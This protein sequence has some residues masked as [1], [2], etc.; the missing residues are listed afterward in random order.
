MRREAGDQRGRLA[1][2]LLARSHEVFQP[3][4][5]YL[6]KSGAP[7]RSPAARRGARPR[8]RGWRRDR[9]PC[10]SRRGRPVRGG[11]GGA[12]ARRRGAAPARRR[13]RRR[14]GTSRAARRPP[15]AAVTSSET[16]DGA[17][18]PTRRQRH[19]HLRGS[20]RRRQAER[21][22]VK[23]VKQCD[24]RVAG[25]DSALGSVV[26]PVRRVVAATVARAAARP[27]RAP[28]PPRRSPGLLGAGL[29]DAAGDAGARRRP[30]RRLGAAAAAGARALRRGRRWSPASRWACSSARRSS[31]LPGGLGGAARRPRARPRP[32]PPGILARAGRRA[33]GRGRR[34][35]RPAA[36]RRQDAEPEA[37]DDRR[38]G[39]G[40]A[41]RRRSPARGRARGAARRCA[42]DRRAPAPPARAGRDR[43]PAAGAAAAAACWR[44][45]FALSRADWR[46]LDLGPL[47]R[48]RRSRS[49]SASAHGLFWY[50]SPPGAALARALPARRRS[51]SLAVA[52]PRSSALA[53]GRAPARGVAASA[54]RSPTARWGCASA[55]GAGAPR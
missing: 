7:R 34:R 47:V 26:S 40:A 36:A 17:T 31:A 5:T 27:P 16:R 42:R 18:E 21:S 1:L 29:V 19:T 13:G 52:W 44:S 49:C 53:V 10:G 35:R 46:V 32:S 3:P 55:L 12:A 11:G 38:G 30:R 43:P 33:G 50:R 2:V 15:Q 45:S 28:S 14:V 8:A 9:S 39:H 48:A 6:R 4:S 37:G 54:R 22:G 25:A 23:S 51:R 41:G 20:T 24:R